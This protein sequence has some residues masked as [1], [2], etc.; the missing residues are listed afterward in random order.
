MA[1]VCGN[2]GHCFQ[3]TG[4]CL[5]GLFLCSMPSTVTRLTGLKEVLMKSRDQFQ[6]R[7]DVLTILE[8][9]PPNAQH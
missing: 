3:T 9:N 6:E 1:A 2:T 5:S 7:A 4:E 8:S